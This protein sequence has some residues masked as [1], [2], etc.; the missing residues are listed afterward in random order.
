VAV[1]FDAA[2]RSTTGFDN[3]TV[4]WTHTPV[5]IPRGVTV[6]VG[7]EAAL[8]QV[9]GVTY[10]GVA[11]TRVRTAHRT[12]AEAGGC[13]G[14]F[15]GSGISTGPQTVTV[16][17]NPSSGTNDWAACCVTWTA[18]GDTDGSVGNAATSA[19]AANPSLAVSPTAQ[20]GIHYGLW[21]GL[22]AVIT[23]VQAGGTH[24]F[25]NDFG[26]DIM[27]W[28]RKTVASGGATTMGYTAASDVHAHLAIAVQ[29]AA[30]GP[31]TRVP[32]LRRRSGR[33]VRH[34]SARARVR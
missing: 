10:G 26:A 5:G 16:T 23:T 22:A 15:L 9:A 24:I 25:G 27:L 7:I 1:A 32:L 31:G 19:A 6:I 2:T 20:A 13:F 17:M 29:E 21:S 8:D 30:G 34:G 33:P 28:S 18:A 14:Y 4:S 11:M 12:T 3:N